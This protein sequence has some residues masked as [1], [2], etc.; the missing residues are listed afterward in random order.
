MLNIC[1]YS[2]A[3]TLL[4]HSLTRLKVEKNASDILRAALRLIL[5]LSAEA[6]GPIPYNTPSFADNDN[7]SQ[8][9]LAV[10]IWI[11]TS[12]YFIPKQIVFALSLSSLVTRSSEDLVNI[13]AAILL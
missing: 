9:R 12:M 7:H 6:C 10:D 2:Y 11:N 13:L 1:A 8:E 4:I 3:L 5:S